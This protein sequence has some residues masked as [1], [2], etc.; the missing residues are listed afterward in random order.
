MSLLNIAQKIELLT[1]KNSFVELR[2]HQQSNFQN[3][4]KDGDGVVCGFAK[5]EQRSVLLILQDAEYLMGTMG[6]AH[7]K[8][9][10]YCIEQAIQNKVPFL[11]VFESAGVRIQEG[12]QAMNAAGALFH[13]LSKASGI[14]PSISI[15]LGVNS[16]AAPYSAAL[17]DFIILE[18]KKGAFFLTGPKIIEKVLNEKT[19]VQTLGGAT[20]QASVTGLASLLAKNENDAFVKAKKLLQFL[21]QHWQEN[22]SINWTEKSITTSDN[23]LEKYHSSLDDFDMYALIDE[24]TDEKSFLEINKYYAANV[25]VGFGK[26]NG[27]KVSII[28]SQPNIMSGAIDKAASKKI[29]RFVQ[30]CDSYHIPLIFLE[31]TPGFMPGNEEEHNGIIGYGAKVIQAISNSSNIKITIIVGKAIG[32]AYGAMCPKTMGADYVFAWPNAQIG[33]IGTEAAMSLIYAKELEENKH[34]ASYLDKKKSMYEATHL[35]PYIAA[36]DGLIDGIIEPNQTKKVLIKCLMSLQNK[37]VVKQQH[38]P[39]LPM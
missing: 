4:K 39:I 33:V 16:G 20:V 24:L 9:M 19:D 2:S 34:D 13:V 3:K 18:D 17:M 38:S 8:K 35:S 15:I 7:C 32:G 22:P 37:A 6:E 21:P 27:C 12:V 14:I 23:S 10:T 29:F 25:I 5:I 31:D 11:I 36:K 30:I 28:A 1:D 26:I